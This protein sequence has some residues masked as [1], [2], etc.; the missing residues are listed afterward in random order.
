LTLEEK[1]RDVLARL[2]TLSEAKASNLEP[3]TSHGASDS[4]VPAGVAERRPVQ[5]TD[6]HRPPPKERSLFDFYA[7]QF[8]HAD[9]DDEGRLLDLWLLAERDY[10]AR[11]LHIPRRVAVRSGED[12]IGKL[13]G[14][15]AE[16]E[17][18]KRVVELYEGRSAEE[19]AVFEY[20]TV[21]VIHKARKMHK[22]NLDDGR[23]RPP[24]LDWTEDER[25]RQVDL[26]IA[27]EKDQDRI[28]GAKAIAKHFG[29]DKNTVKRY[30]EPEPVAA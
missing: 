4:R 25:R 14:E 6:P 5:A 19:A 16:R 27:R 22:R 20:T 7:W 13:S 21:Q 15:A 17:A 18:A 10:H 29:V 28:I 1:I 3:R 24:F 23:P 11:A 8:A 12:A 26:L 30:L 9:P 2:S